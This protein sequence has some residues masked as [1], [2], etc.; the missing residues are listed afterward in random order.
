MGGRSVH[1]PVRGGIAAVGAVAL[2]LT[3]GCSAGGD[4]G[5]AGGDA[6]SGGQGTSSTKVQPVQT[7]AADWQPVADAL[8]RP[9]KLSDNTVYRVS[10]PRSDT[11][12]VSQGVRIEP[13]LA[14]GSY[15]A[16]TRY[17]DGSALMMGDLVVTEEE[18]PRVTSALQANGIEQTAIHKHLLQTS[19]PIWW[20]HIHAHG[21]AADI[22]RGVRAALDQTATP[23]ATG[24]SNAQ[25]P[26]LDL[27]TAGID[28]ALGRQGTA[29]G[30][31]YKI[32]VPRA[33]TITDAG[34][35]TPP[36]MGV[37]TALNFQPTGGGRAAIN[38]DFAMTGNEVQQ[39]IQALRAGGITVVSLHNHAITDDPHVY[40][41]HFWANDDAVTL[42]RA[43][44]TALDATNAKPAR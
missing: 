42:A 9:G 21:N 26:A 33:D 28:Q 30:G 22:A 41:T 34:M 27:D 7:G 36:G 15:A 40:F 29:E 35:V 5:S 8:G 20:T 13:A 24:T 3:G 25:P 11:A 17:P 23:P 19:P 39:V 10:F 31:V 2:L 32:S 12:V 43:L 38:G 18:L 16:F 6:T 1:R 44:R 14:L 37:T 4:S